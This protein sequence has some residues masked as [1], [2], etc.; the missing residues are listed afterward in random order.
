MFPFVGGQNNINYPMFQ[1]GLFLDISLPRD[2]TI[3]SALNFVF[4]PFYC[5]LKGKYCIRRNKD[6]EK[7]ICMQNQYFFYFW[8]AKFKVDWARET[9]N[10]FVFAKYIEEC[11]KRKVINVHGYLNVSLL[12]ASATVIDTLLQRYHYGHQVHWTQ[13]PFNFPRHTWK[14]KENPHSH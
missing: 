1:D 10:Y 9:K 2:S 12:S 6:S 13:S 4:Y 7:S 3:S 11:R 8:I 14:I 5:N